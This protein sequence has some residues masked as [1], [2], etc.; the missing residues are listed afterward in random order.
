MRML[1]VAAARL[2][3]VMAAALSLA[4]I[5]AG[6]NSMERLLVD[7]S[8]AGEQDRWMLVTDT[9]MGG[10]ST[11]SWRISPD[12]TARFRGR[13]RIGAFGGFVSARW[14]P[15]HFD[16]TGF[17]GIALRVRGDG[18]IYRLRL[19]N[20]DR[21]EAIAYQASFT[22]ETGDAEGWT[23]VR[24]PFREFVAAHHGTVLPD[25]APLDPAEIRQIGIMIADPP[26]GEFRL[27]IDWIKAYRSDLR[28]R[29]GF[30]KEPTC[31]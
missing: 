23:T 2:A 30:I 12:R 19:R 17:E 15:R 25:A 4:G 22:A 31:A 7:F 9:V 10:G 3:A 1:P 14:A 21:F 13:L 6:P 20:E 18:R 28:T 24:V 11:G 5:P 29:R 8:A 26:E 27:E 16:L